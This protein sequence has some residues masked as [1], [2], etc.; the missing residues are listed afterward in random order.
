M[1]K[2]ITGDL[3]ALSRRPPTP[4]QYRAALSG[5]RPHAVR[6]AA[7]IAAAQLD[8]ALFVALIS[9]LKPL[10]REDMYIFENDGPYATTAQKIDACYSLG[11]IGPKSK[12]ETKTINR[13]RNA[14]S[15]ATA[16]VTFGTDAI[17][18]AIRS[19][20]TM[21]LFPEFSDTRQ[22]RRSDFLWRTTKDR[23][24]TSIK[25]YCEKLLKYYEEMR[26]PATIIKNGI[27]SMRWTPEPLP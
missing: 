8:F 18:A 16:N 20:N 12:K 11:I 5:L 27:A 3:L 13:V 14:F 19:L 23:Y 10:S 7:V 4:D 21:E 26:R 9:K 24:V 22:Y 17:E 15:H 25:I 1:P 2:N 6:G